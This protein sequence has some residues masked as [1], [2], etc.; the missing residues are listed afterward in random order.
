MIQDYIFELQ[1][2]HSYTD[3]YL[4]KHFAVQL[5]TFYIKDPIKVSPLVC[6][7]GFFKKLK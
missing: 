4:L 3:R 7:N 2:H 6:Y 1:H 5:I